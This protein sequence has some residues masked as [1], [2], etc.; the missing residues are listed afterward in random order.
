MA[1]AYDGEYHVKTALQF[2]HSVEAVDNISETPHLDC[3]FRDFLNYRLFASLSRQEPALRG[4]WRFADLLEPRK[5]RLSSSYPR[6]ESE[7]EK[8][9]E[10]AG[11]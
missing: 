5:D 1:G 7:M 11:L 8:V 10:S 3:I 9:A 6:D 4:R 2:G